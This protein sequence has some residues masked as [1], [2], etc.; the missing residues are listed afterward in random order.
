M[1]KDK[2]EKLAEQYQRKADAAYENYQE[3]G[4]TRYNTA[5]RNNEDIAD[6]LRMAAAA[7]DD[8]D[9]MIC[10]RHE[11]YQL[12]TKADR[13]NRAAEEQKTEEMQKVIN[14]LLAVARLQGL[15]GSDDGA[16]V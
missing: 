16:G 6:A 4:I 1:T 13:A 9:K 2:L 7:K 11:L 5:R 8:H 3:T 12:A 15:I 10:L 14:S